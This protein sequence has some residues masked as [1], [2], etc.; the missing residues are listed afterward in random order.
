MDTVNNKNYL[1]IIISL[2]LS[3]SLVMLLV[4]FFNSIF[5]NSNNGSVDDSKN[6]ERLVEHFENIRETKDE[7]DLKSGYQEIVDFIFNESKINGIS[8]KELQEETKTKIISIGLKIDSK[9]NELFPNYKE[10]FG[11]KYRD[12]KEKMSLMF[13]DITSNICMDNQ[14]LCDKSLEI[15]NDVK[16]EIVV[17]FNKLKEISD[18]EFNKVKD[19]FKEYIG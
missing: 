1:Y 12:I 8:F 14:K 18:H 4:V 10:N 5:N 19:F 15:Y 2:L 13:Y 9:I 11:E 3:L 16:E 17:D 7:N 6:E